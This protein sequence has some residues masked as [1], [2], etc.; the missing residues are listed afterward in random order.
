MWVFTKY[1]FV[2]VACAS[3]QDGEIDEGTVMVR[4]SVSTEWR[5]SASN[6][7]DLCHATPPANA[8]VPRQNSNLA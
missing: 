2:S 7:Y 4:A 6:E 1:G 5:G 3:K 8:A